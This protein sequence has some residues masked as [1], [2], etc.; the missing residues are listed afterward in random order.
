[1]NWYVM[2]WIVNVTVGVIMAVCALVMGV[3]IVA[4]GLALYDGATAE[5]FELRKDQWTCAKSHTES[6][7][8]LIG[9]VVAPQSQTVCDV[10]QRQ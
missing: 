10:W 7:M 2:D 3:C 1:M 8:V 6:R 5:T 4:L 9:K